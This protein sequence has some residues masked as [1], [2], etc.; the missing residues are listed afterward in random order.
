MAAIVC[1]L[2]TLYNNINQSKIQ[3]NILT[4]MQWV[5]TYVFMYVGM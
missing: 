3:A 5:Y 4:Y 1:L 2:L